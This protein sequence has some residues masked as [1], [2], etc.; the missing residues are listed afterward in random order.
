MDII[1]IHIL[2]YARTLL[3]NKYNIYI[4]I[5]YLLFNKKTIFQKSKSDE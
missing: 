1:N 4:L 2:M 5:V 3:Y